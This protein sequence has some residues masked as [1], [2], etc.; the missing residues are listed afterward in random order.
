MSADARLLVEVQQLE[1]L[2][3]RMHKDE[4]TCLPVT[5]PDTRK[6]RSLQARPFPIQWSVG[7][8]YGPVIVM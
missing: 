5:T 3:E 2:A 4:L 7:T 6:G 1:A 8:G